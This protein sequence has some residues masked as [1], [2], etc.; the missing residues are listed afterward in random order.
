M[1]NGSSFVL[2]RSGLLLI[3]LRRFI[4]C[5][6]VKN[7]RRS[8]LSVSLAALVVLFWPATALAATP[9]VGLGTAGNFAV[10]AGQTITNSG[11]TWISGQLGLSPGAPPACAMTGF[12]GASTGVKHKCDAVALK[13]KADLKTAYLDAA[14][15]TPCTTLTGGLLGGRNLVSGVYCATSTADL[16]GTL[17]LSGTGVFIFQIGSGLTA[18]VS[19]RV[20][21][22]NGAQPCQVFW[23][24]TSSAVIKGSSAFVG[25]IMALTSISMGTRATLEGRALARNGS[26][27]LLTNRIIQPGGC[28][29]NAPALG[30]SPGGSPPLPLSLGF[31]LSIP[32]NGVPNELRGEQ[33]PWLLVIGLGAGAG[34]V[35]MGV[36][37]R[38]RRRI[39]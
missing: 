28:G 26:V 8:V 36:I 7:M 38:R 21:L 24:V 25:T 39:A 23:Q 12:V 11:P 2:G 9:P 15:R 16:I 19:S 4:H 17:T 6:E 3:L 32:S 29:Y 14:G 35:A 22:I 13:A 10:L 33:F 30:T 5:D 31:S 37:A 34:V 18:E 1:D 20:H 27:T